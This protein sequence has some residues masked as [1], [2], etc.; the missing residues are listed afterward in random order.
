[1]DIVLNTLKSKTIWGVIIGLLGST[2][3]GSEIV[4]G[5]GI[6]EDSAVGFIDKALITFGTIQTVYG[7]LVA[8]AP[9][10]KDAS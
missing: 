4:T 1:M 9:L 3:W 2:G 10:V 7:R 8:K 5:F 6:T